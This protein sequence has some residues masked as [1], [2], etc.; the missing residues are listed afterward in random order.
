MLVTLSLD[1]LDAVRNPLSFGQRENHATHL[2]TSAWVVS[3][4]FSLP[5]VFLNS[6]ITVRGVAQCW[7]QLEAWQWRLYITIVCLTLFCIP[8]L[9]IAC[10]Y[11][12]I[13]L[14]IWRK[15]LP[16]T[17]ICAAQP[18]PVAVKP[19]CAAYK[20]RLSF[21]LNHDPDKNAS[22]DC[23]Y[24][25]PADSRPTMSRESATIAS[26]ATFSDQMP[27]SVVRSTVANWFDKSLIRTDDKKGKRTVQMRFSS[28]GVIPKARI[29]TIK[30][31][32]V[33]VLGK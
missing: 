31:T 3:A 14:R 5:A 6:Q 30:M 4:L 8:A 15:P 23:T 29:K 13:V 16:L 7:I 18:L 2:V 27:P 26:N 10:C 20:N 21:R 19:T 24:A 11:V 12:L 22:E 32:F 25:E 17:R 1:R 33:I 9:V 28:E